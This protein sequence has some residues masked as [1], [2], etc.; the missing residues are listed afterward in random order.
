MDFMG[1]YSPQWGK[2]R[3]KEIVLCEFCK[4]FGKVPLHNDN[5]AYD[6]PLEQLCPVCMGKGRRW[7]IVV[8]EFDLFDS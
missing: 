2:T 7:R 8:T 3:S 4:G 6:G 1:I 5:P